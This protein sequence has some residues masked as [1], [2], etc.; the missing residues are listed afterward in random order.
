MLKNFVHHLVEVV[1]VELETWINITV[2]FQKVSLFTVLS[3]KTSNGIKEIPTTLRLTPN[4]T[5]HWYVGDGSAGKHELTLNTQSFNEETS[6]EGSRS[7]SETEPDY[8]F[9]RL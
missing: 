1:L 8:Q 9:Q 2:K 5:L 4:T 7:Q 6:E 3:L